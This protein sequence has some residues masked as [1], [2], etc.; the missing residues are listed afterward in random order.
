MGRYLSVR[1]KQDFIND[2]SI[3]KINEQLVN[4]Y[5]ATERVKFNPSYFIDEEADFLNN[6]P[7]GK[8]QAPH[9]KRPLTR[10]FLSHNF[11]WFRSG[12]L[13]IKISGGTDLEAARDAVAVCKWIIHTKGWYIDRSNSSNYSRATIAQYLN[14]IFKEADHSLKDVWA[15]PSTKP[16]LKKRFL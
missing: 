5:G 16:I 12:E 14:Y 8:K 13:H 1:L 9:L 6:D 15:M 7:E 4:S 10:E 2:L 11:F 3:K